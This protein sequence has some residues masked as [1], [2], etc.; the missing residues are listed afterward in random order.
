VSDTTPQDPEYFAVSLGMDGSRLAVGASLANTVGSYARGAAY[1]YT[2]LPVPTLTSVKES[3]ASW[4]PDASLPKLNPKKAPKGGTAYR[5]TT[6]QAMPVALG[7][8][9]LGKHGKYGKTKVFVVVAKKGRNVVY[10][11]GRVSKSVKLSAG[12]YR[13]VLLAEN[14]TGDKSAGHTL[15]FTV[16]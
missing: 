13:V 6:N 15:H 8:A 1:L 7:F 10:F 4:K 11:G 12:K 14:A 2:T 5:F 16:K 3:R 9:K